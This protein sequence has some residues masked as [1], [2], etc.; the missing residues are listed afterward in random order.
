MVAQIPDM[1]GW[2]V[3]T[4]IPET[5]RA[6]LATGQQAIVRPKA[7]PGRE[8]KGHISLLGGLREARGIERSTAG[9]RST[10]PMMRCGLV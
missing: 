10:M 2:E 4:Q 1:S 8:F 7:M 9:S 5:D 6:F 3:S